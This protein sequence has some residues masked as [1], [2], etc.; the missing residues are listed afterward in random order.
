MVDFGKPVL[1]ENWATESSLDA[2]LVGSV[3]LMVDLAPLCATSCLFL[4][5]CLLAI[6]LC[7]TGGYPV[8]VEQNAGPPLMRVVNTYS[9]RKVKDGHLGG[10][11]FEGFLADFSER[12]CIRPPLFLFLQGGVAGTSLDGWSSTRKVSSLRNACQRQDV[13]FVCK[14]SRIYNGLIKSSCYR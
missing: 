6:A 3:V 8:G 14:C 5:L 12:W 1:F 7:R 11:K 10:L 4:S 2:L 9:A 13:D